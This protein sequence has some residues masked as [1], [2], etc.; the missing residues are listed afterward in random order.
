MKCLTPIWIEETSDTKGT[1]VPCGRCVNCLETKRSV[2]TF[3]LLM[4]LRV[5]E[6][7]HFVTLTYDPLDVPYIKNGSSYDM[8]LKKNICNRLLNILGSISSE[9]WTNWKNQGDGLS[10]QRKRKNGALSYVISRVA[11]MVHKILNV[12]TITWCYITAPTIISKMTRFT[13]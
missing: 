3:R 9:I 11:N 7:A 5:A 6:S 12:P 1:Y 10:N 8:T 13:G 2:W 4:E